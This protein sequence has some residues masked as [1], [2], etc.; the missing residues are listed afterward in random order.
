[1][2]ASPWCEMPEAQQCKGHGHG[3]AGWAREQGCAEPSGG[4]AGRLH[5]HTPAGAGALADL[6][7]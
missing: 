5:P 2:L 4:R 3:L 7:K 6:W 1:M